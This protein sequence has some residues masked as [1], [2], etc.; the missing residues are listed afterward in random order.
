MAHLF[1]PTA[2]SMMLFRHPR[3]QEFSEAALR[4]PVLKKAFSAMNE[5]TGHVALIYRN[6]GNGGGLQ[7]S[8]LPSLLLNWA[9]VSLKGAE[10]NQASLAEMALQG[11]RLIRDAL[12]GKACEINAHVAFTGVLLPE[13]IELQVGRVGVGSLDH[14]C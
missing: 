7:L 9:W 3:A 2:V 1:T 14:R 4:D 13:G 10:V 6:T 8:M 12:A 5:A 11:L